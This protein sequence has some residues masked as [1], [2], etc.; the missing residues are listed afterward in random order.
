MVCVLFVK[1]KFFGCNNLIVM[2]FAENIHF[3]NDLFGLL[4][5]GE[6]WQV[7]VDFEILVIISRIDVDVITL[8]STHFGYQRIWQ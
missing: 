6:V 4:K 8:R 3:S 1:S 5:Y 7:Q 2:I